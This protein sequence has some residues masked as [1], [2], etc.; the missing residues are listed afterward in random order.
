MRAVTYSRYGGPEV[1]AVTDL[2][3]P[4][5]AADE[6]L[7][8]V[9]AASVGSA[10]G[11]ARRGTPRVVRLFSGLFRPRLSVLGSDFAG[12]VVAVGADVTRFTVGDRVVGASGPGL[13]CHAEYVTA[14]A[15]GVIAPLPRTVSY[16]WGAAL[17]DGALTALPF[18]R[19]GGRIQP[20]YRVLV[21][22]ASGSVGSAAVQLAKHAGAHVTAV[23]SGPN[24]QLVKGLGADD[25]IDYLTT[26]FTTGDARYDVVF[27]AIG[28]SSFDAARRVLTSHGRFLST[29]PS[30]FLRSLFSRRSIV[31]FTGLRS[32]AKVAP[33]VSELADLAASG[34]IHPL[35][36]SRYTLDDAA[37]AHARVDSERKRGTV[38]LTP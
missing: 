9:R 17:M 12:E 6:V 24:V 19:D 8:R 18:L 25:V 7:V 29:V 4:E 5:P 36:D 11:A 26:D 13:G 3:T 22:G 21:N 15:T 32:R 34:R 35:I 10:D 27:D 1:V 20:G 33:D 28:K 23:T 31:L 14:K 38:I 16:E 30:A 2:P 37:A